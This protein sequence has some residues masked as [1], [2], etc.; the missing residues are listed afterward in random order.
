MTTT[1]VSGTVTDVYE[2]FDCSFPKVTMEWYR[3]D[4]G[5]CYVYLRNLP[6]HRTVEVGG[7]G[8]VDLAETGEVIGFEDHGVPWPSNQSVHADRR[9]RG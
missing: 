6:R 9:P 4:M 3:P 1:G 7:S 5:A 8:L 2:Y